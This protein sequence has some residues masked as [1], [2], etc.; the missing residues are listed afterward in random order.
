MRGVSAEVDSSRPVSPAGTL[1]G[2]AVAPRVLRPAEGVQ[3][4]SGPFNG[5]AQTE[6]RAG[7]Y[8][9][10]L[11]RRSHMQARH[12]RLATGR[13]NAARG[14]GGAESAGACGLNGASGPREPPPRAPETEHAPAGGERRAVDAGQ[15][16]RQ[17]PHREACD[18]GN[19]RAEQRSAVGGAL[20]DVAKRAFETVSRQ[21]K[22]GSVSLE[23][24]GAALLSCGVRLAGDEAG[25]ELQLQLLR[26]ELLRAQCTSSS[27]HPRPGSCAFSARGERGVFELF[28]RLARER[29]G[30]TVLPS[31]VESGGSEPEVH[32]MGGSVLYPEAGG[33]PLLRLDRLGGTPASR[34][35]TSMS[36]REHRDR[37]HSSRLGSLTSRDGRSARASQMPQGPISSEL[38][39]KEVQRARAQYVP[40]SQVPRSGLNIAFKSSEDLKVPAYVCELHS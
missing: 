33:V 11:V 12:R 25:D 4:R 35:P 3:R 39:M 22:A 17:S 2:S 23:D 13:T 28:L 18:E 15:C 30:R 9:L 10:S 20:E 7:S 21:L 34:I 14:G 27:S 16:R 29:G 8:E 6:C 1:S 40:Q 38:V 5:P 24:L 19:R 32:G 36:A 26:A 37:V 31:I